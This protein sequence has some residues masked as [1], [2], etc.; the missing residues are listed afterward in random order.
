MCTFIVLFRFLLR[1]GIA[2]TDQEIWRV[3]DTWRT[4][5]VP[6]MHNV[7]S[8]VWTNAQIFGDLKIQP[9]HLFRCAKNCQLLLNNCHYT[10]C[11]RVAKL[12]IYWIRRHRI[13]L[14]ES[15]S[16]RQRVPARMSLS[17]VMANDATKEEIAV[18]FHA[19]RIGRTDVLKV[20]IEL[21][22]FW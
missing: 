17:L 3:H 8:L 10:P 11:P 22:K 1:F 2:S 20:R 15:L 13:K 7:H 16:L 12:A 21:C 9:S 5:P 6:M 19:A 4:L 18:I 14:F